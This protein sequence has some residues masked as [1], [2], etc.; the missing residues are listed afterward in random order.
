[1]L[2]SPADREHLIIRETPIDREIL[3]QHQAA[4]KISIDGRK[5][6]EQDLRA[7]SM[8]PHATHVRLTG[9]RGT[10]GALADLPHLQDLHLIDPH[11][12]DGLTKLRQLTSLTVYCFPKIHSLTPIASLTNLRSL[13]LSTPPGYDASRKCHEVDSLDPLEHLQ[14]LE[15]LTLRGVLPARGRLNPLRTLKRLHQLAITHV[16]TFGIEDYARLA[17]ALPNTSGHCL[18]PYYEAHW[19]GSCRS[20]GKPRVALTAP[21]PRTPRTICPDCDHLRLER[22][23]AEWNAAMV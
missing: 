8:L 14:N 23:I 3:S 7:L 6:S 18:R 17:R 9:M 13:L 15:R 19:A 16:Y 12:L 11:A 4:W 5:C 22:H 1:V 21:P 20:C 2:V 10:L